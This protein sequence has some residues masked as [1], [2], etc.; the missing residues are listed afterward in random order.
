MPTPQV[1]ASTPLDAIVASGQ[2][3]KPMAIFKPCRSIMTT[4]SYIDSVPGNILPPFIALRTPAKS[5]HAS[6]TQYLS[7]LPVCVDD[8]Y[9]ALSQPRQPPLW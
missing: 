1:N 2:G 9:P 4:S 3:V 5:R 8:M 7:L 6:G